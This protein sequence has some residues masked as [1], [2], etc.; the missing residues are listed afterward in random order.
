MLRRNQL[1]L[2]NVPLMILAFVPLKNLAFVPLM[3]LAFVPLKNLAFVPL[4]ILAFV[5]LTILAFV[6]PPAFVPPL[7]FVLYLTIVVPLS[8]LKCPFGADSHFSNSVPVDPSIDL[9]IM[10]SDS[11][12]PLRLKP[13]IHLISDSQN[14]LIVGTSTNAAIMCNSADIADLSSDGPPSDLGFE[15]C[16]TTVNKGESIRIIH[17]NVRSMKDCAALA[18]FASE[19]S[20]DIVCL[21]ET[22]QRGDLTQIQS[23]NLPWLHILWSKS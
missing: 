10:L 3:I 9:D 2:A 8:P 23:L 17:A 1:L 21:S 5:P 14:V 11:P 7:A 12:M 19:K 15:F 6:L 18:D 13:P 20:A 22:W 16:T 4:M